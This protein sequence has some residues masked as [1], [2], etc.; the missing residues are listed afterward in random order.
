MRSAEIL[1]KCLENEGVEY[2]FGVPGE[3]N[4]DMM[5]ALLDSKI[6]F[7]TTRHETGAAFMAGIMGKLTGKP[8]VCLSTLGPGATNML[9]GVADGNMDR[10]PIVAITGQAGLNRLHKES[11]QAYDLIAMYSPVTKWNTRIS[12]AESIP[13]IV[14]KAFKIAS[15]EKPGAT[16]IEYP[17][18]IA[19]M[20]MEDL[21]PLNVTELK[22]SRA[23]IKSFEEAKELINKAK[24]PLIIAGNGV[25]R[26]KSSEELTLFAEKIQ[27]PVTETFMGKGSIS[28]KHPLS[29][30]AVGLTFKDYVSCALEKSDLIIAVGYDMTEIPPQRFNPEGDI[31]IVHIDTQNAEVDSHYP[32][33]CNVVG[34]IASNL[35]DLTDLLKKRDQPADYVEGVRSRIL[36]EHHK[37]ENDTNFPLKPQKIVYDLRKVMGEDDIAL[38]DTG[39]HKMWMARMYHCYQPN[40]CLISNGLASMG[41][42]VPGAIAAKMVHPDK[43]VVAVVGDGAFL[44]NGMDLETAVRLKLPIVILIWHDD[45][46]GLIEWKQKMAF[47]RSSNIKY[48]DPDFV[49]LAEAY[50]A[51]GIRI[52]K[53]DELQQALENATKAD[54]PVVIDCPVD[55]SENMKLSERMQNLQCD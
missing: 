47:N 26:T 22:Q 5:D 2:I 41:I 29:L 33:V 35:H 24:S 19:G 48:G 6:K 3:E 18:D 39:A 8:G 32:V 25:I 20:E 30:M 43:K 9:T 16:H 21:P 13:E 15:S 38:S 44:M 31:P 23:S 49:K 28:W 17:E 10:T 7:I 55:Y 34:D 42:A 40:T 4:I 37:Y 1:L 46:Y 50:G 52:K 54:G 53:A 45:A 27:A 12:K 14:R 11:H 36:E 51:T